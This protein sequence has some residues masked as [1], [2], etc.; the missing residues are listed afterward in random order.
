MLAAGAAP[1]IVRVSSLMPLWTPPAE[2][3]L[4]TLEEAYALGAYGIDPPTNREHFEMLWS[5]VKRAIDQKSGFMAAISNTA[6][7]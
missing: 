6:K 7:G 2:I 1:A 4:P 5:E 3:V